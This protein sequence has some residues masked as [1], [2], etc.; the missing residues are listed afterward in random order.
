[1]RHL[2]LVF[3]LA[4]SLPAA[5]ASTVNFDF[6]NTSFLPNGAVGASFISNGYK[7]SVASPNTMNHSA[8]GLDIPGVLT[9][10][11][12]DNNVFTLNSL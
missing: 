7:L 2:F 10:T 4:T 12:T 1:M 5:A 8:Y 6:T 3:A 9:I 11:R